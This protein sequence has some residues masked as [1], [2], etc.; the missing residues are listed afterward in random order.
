MR[1]KYKAILFDFDGTLVPSLDYWFAGFRHAFDQLGRP[2][3]D[4]EI[5]SGCFYKDDTAISAAFGLE[6]TRTF[7]DLVQTKIKS[8]YDT[9]AL[10]PGVADVLDDCAAKGIPMALVTSSERPV[11]H[12]AFSCLPLQKYFDVVVTASD[13]TNLK[14]HPEPI[15][16]ALDGLGLGATVAR[17]TL[18]VGDYLVDVLAGKAAGCDVGL[19][20]NDSH[21]RYHQR[22][23]LQNSE[24]DFVFS[25]FREL[26]SRY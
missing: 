13:V 21:E 26:A 7:W 12:K 2:V 19:F 20:H 15:L 9:A 25:D 14:P 8:C 5:L 1:K 10:F 17:E 22:E 18:F 16:T 24:A 6:C 11:I 23:H 4:Q 3:T